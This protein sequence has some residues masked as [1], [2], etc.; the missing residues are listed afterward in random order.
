MIEGEEKGTQEAQVEQTTTSVSANQSLNALEGFGELISQATLDE[1]TE[2]SNKREAET[3]A[4]EKAQTTLF[5]GVNDQLGENA[6]T[7]TQTTP[8]EEVISESVK[9]EE[10]KSEE[11]ETEIEGSTESGATLDD[12]FSKVD[13]PLL[14]GEQTIGKANEPAGSETEA[15]NFESIE[16]LSG[17]LKENHGI[18]DIKDL[19]SQIEDWKGKSQELS[20]LSVKYSNVENLFKTMPKE[21]HGAIQNFIDNKDWKE[22]LKSP[23]IDYSKN[24]NDFS[25]KDVVES[26][27]PGKITAEDWEEFKEDEGDPNIKRLVQSTIDTSRD[28]FTRKKGLVEA[29]AVNSVEIAKQNENLYVESMSKSRESFKASFGDADS[30]IIEEI[31]Q[32]LSQ[33]GGLTS[34]FFNE[35]G[36]IREDAFLRVAMSKHG[37]GL[38]NQYK[39]IAER[40]IETK[41]TQDILATGAST[42]STSKG[43]KSSQSKEGVREDVQKEIDHIKGLV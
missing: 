37:E 23:S 24:V 41:I 16:N 36:T 29:E 4:A 35:N 2:V 17:F 32:V 26:M 3:A 8:A 25:D 27:M 9:K 42:P 21:L 12:E 10:A 28:M 38:L 19:G 22:G 15:A 11:G 33:P 18:D 6:K 30:S 39:T 40:K 14:G 34:L 7:E 43:S 13:S 20:D 5:P 31:E 1:A